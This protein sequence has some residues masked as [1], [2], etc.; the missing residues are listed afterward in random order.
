MV[1]DL[2]SKM[3]ET[4][5]PRLYWR[6]L[7]NSEKLAEIGP[8]LHSWLLHEKE[9][10]GFLHD[11]RSE[12]G[13]EDNS[14][15]SWTLSFA[16]RTASFSHWT[17]SPLWTHLGLFE[18]KRG[19]HTQPWSSNLKLWV[20]RLFVYLF[21]C[22]SP[23]Q[24]QVQ[25]SSLL[26]K[27]GRV[28]WVRRTADRIYRQMRTIRKKLLRWWRDKIYY[29]LKWISVVQLAFFFTIKYKIENARRFPF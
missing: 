7:W 24:V 4:V 1:R 17:L 22:F 5:L 23:L 6:R 12:R 10:P 8:S 16:H 20:V 26:W 19:L 18:K 11:A 13:S 27:S 3:E 2:R 25:L 14:Q 15:S 29:S 21:V 28:P 9:A